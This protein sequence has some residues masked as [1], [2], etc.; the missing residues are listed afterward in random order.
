MRGMGLGLKLAV[1]LTLV[2]GGDAVEGM[3]VQAG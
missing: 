2:V 3:G 1:R